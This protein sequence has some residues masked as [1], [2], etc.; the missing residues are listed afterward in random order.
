[1]PSPS[2]AT[3][4]Q[5]KSTS[6]PTLAGTTLSAR[7]SRIDLLSQQHRDSW[8]RASTSSGDA[9]A[10]PLLSGSKS[11]DDIA[12]ARKSAHRSSMSH[13]YNTAGKHRSQ[14]YEDQFRYKDSEAGSV[15]EKVQRESPV[16]AELKT[17]VIIKDEYTLVT[18]LSYHLAQRYTRPDSSIMIK[19]D[20]SVCLALGGTFDPCYI[21][22]VTTVPSSMGPSI[23]KRNAALIQSFMADILSVPSDRGIVKFTPIEEVNY[24][25]NGTT[26]HGEIERLEKHQAENGGVGN[27]VR[28]AVTNASRR[29]LTS[30]TS[31]GVPPKLD[32]DVKTPSSA[33][34]PNGVSASDHDDD[35]K[36]QKR[37]SMTTTPPPSSAIPNVFELAATESNDRPSTAH[38]TPYAAENG[39]RMNGISKEDLVGSAA[40]TPN[41]RPKTFAGSSAS[42]D[43]TAHDPMPSSQQQPQQQPQRPSAIHQRNS[44]YR[45]S[46]AGETAPSSTTT[47]RRSG[48]IPISPK[49]DRTSKAPTETGPPKSPGPP[50]SSASP[51]PKRDT[52]LDNISSSTTTDPTTTTTS[53]TASASASRPKREASTPI[54][55][56]LDA[57]A[58]ERS[59][60]QSQQQQQQQESKDTAAN[61]AKRPST[62]TATPKIP[63]PPPVPQDSSSSRK[64]GSGGGSGAGK[65][66]QRVGK[67]KSFLSA[68]RRSAAA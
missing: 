65:E 52:Y 67:R 27:A 21:L 49:P 63:P 37:K 22:N 53:S 9:S 57:K 50:R 48:N 60:H 32:T 30:S 56:K 3:A 43:H 20:H 13:Q 45:K 29:S 7:D 68:F 1:M 58:S 16:V 26:M 18:D 33:I 14:Y 42:P 15:R 11:I 47:A 25:M 35:A 24:A 23:N 51:L 55:P 59:R 44:S 54:D 34:T 8:K 6:G 2:N 66:Q 10:N 61:T 4:F 19:V 46:V 36:R 31:N 39:L 17:N 62:V 28:R 38:G 64:S 41:G 5:T 12:A 40:R